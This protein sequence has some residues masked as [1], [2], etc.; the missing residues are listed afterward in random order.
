MKVTV[1]DM[2]RNPG[3]ILDAIAQ[4]PLVTEEDL[5]TPER[6]ADFLDHQPLEVQRRTREAA[7]DFGQPEFAAL[8]AR[9]QDA[10]IEGAVGDRPG[11]QA[12]VELVELLLR[13]VGPHIYVRSLHLEPSHPVEAWFRAPGWTLSPEP[14]S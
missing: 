8:A 1:L 4:H 3:K 2:R 7:D 14:P 12:G 11:S 5:A 9:Q 10:A 6:F 13:A